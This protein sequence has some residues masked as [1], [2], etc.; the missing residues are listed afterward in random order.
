[1]DSL[2][3][4]AAIA[5]VAA[6]TLLCA[7]G[8]ARAQGDIHF[9]L[10]QPAAFQ[11]H[12]AI[13]PGTD[14]VYCYQSDRLRVIGSTTNT[15]SNTVSVSIVVPDPVIRCS[16]CNAWGCSSLSPNSAVVTPTHPLDIDQNEVV[17]V[18]DMTMCVSKIRDYI[19]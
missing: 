6:A 16:A 10:G 5:A 14:Q 18:R 9:D 11:V 7:T 12:L 19:Y 1:M 17:D 2:G 13:S 8:N 15:A 4:F 3:R